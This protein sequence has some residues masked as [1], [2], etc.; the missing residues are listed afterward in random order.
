MWSAL[1]KFTVE[2]IFK[3]IKDTK[4]SQ[5]QKIKTLNSESLMMLFLFLIN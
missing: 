1:F 2:I 5:E 3:N 4:P